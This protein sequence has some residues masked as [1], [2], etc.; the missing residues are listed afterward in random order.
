[1]VKQLTLVTPKIVP[2]ADTE[3][4]PAALA[5]R[6]FRNAVKACGNP[7]SLVLGIERADGTR[8]IYK[9]IVFPSNHPRAEENLVYTE[10]IVKFLLWQKGG[11]K[12]YIGGPAEIGEFL[13]KAYTPTGLRKFDYEFMGQTVYEKTFEVVITSA[14]KVPPENEMA[15]PLGRHLEGNRIGFDLGASDRKVAAV[16]DGKDVFSTEVVWDPRNQSD[17]KY[18]FDGIM[19]LIT[20]AS[21]H[22]PKID[23]IGGSSAGVVINNRVMVGSMFR[24]VQ[25]K[26]QE[27]FNKEVKDIFLKIKKEWKNVPLEVVNDGEVTALAGAMTLNT[28][29]VLGI[30]M[31]SSEAAGYV[32]KDGNITNWLNEL[33]FAPIDYNPDGPRDDAWSCDYGVGVQYFSQ[34]AMFRLAKKM[35]IAIDETKTKAE[36]L[37][38]LQNLYKQGDER[39][40]KIYETIGCYLGYGVAHYADFYGIKNV[41]I[42]GRVTS[43][44]GGKIILEKAKEVFTAEFPELVDKIKLHLPEEESTRR[45][46]QAIAAASLPVVK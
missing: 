45:V 20:Q 5:N 40:K 6:E 26:S 17:P 18:H 19:D 1:M 28:D 11:Y 16:I 38:A 21:K 2:P 46:G 10:R 39:L 25:E 9:T 30:A 41:L 12:V 43:G 44:E 35:G 29:S 7:V 15:R 32:N 4:R 36:R 13:K 24:G 37:K 42:L 14:D 23:A 33:A 3:F 27:L 31:G 22:L 34:E 8:S